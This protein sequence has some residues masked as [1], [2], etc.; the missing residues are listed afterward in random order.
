MGYFDNQ[1]RKKN[2]QEDERFSESWHNLT[3][4]VSG[5]KIWQNIQDP[6]L[7]H[8]NCV[9][10]LADWVNVTL[11][12]SSG[13]N[14]TLEEY[15]ETY[16][17]PQGIMWREVELKDDWYRNYMGIMSGHMKDGTEVVFVPGGKT[18]YTFRD[19]ETGKRVRVTKQNADRFERDAVL[20]YRNLP[21]RKINMKDMISFMLK[22]ISGRDII[23]FVVA[24]IVLMIINMVYPAMTK[25][26]ITHQD[27]I[28]RIF[29]L[30]CTVTLIVF[31]INIIK[32][33][34]LPRISTKIAAPLQAAFMMRVLSA[35]SDQMK[36][37]SAGD[38]GSRI[39]GI[40]MNVQYFMNMLLSV[41]LTGICSLVSFVQMFI[42]SKALA[43]IA[44]LIIFVLIVLLVRIGIRQ[45]KVGEARM[46]SGA[47]EQGLTYSMIDGMQKI[48]LSGAEKRAFA[49][50]ADVYR[51][52]MKSIYNPPVLLK[53]FKVLVPALL[54]ISNLPL[55]YVAVSMNMNQADFFAFTSSFAIVTGAISLISMN[56]TEFANTIPMFKTLKPIMDIE[57]EI[58]RNK[59]VIENLRGSIS[60][61]NITFRY[62]EGMPK[63]IDNLTMNIKAGSYV[64]IVGS[65]GCGKSTLIK[66]LLGFEQP[67]MGEIYYD[68]IPLSSVDMTSLRRRI[69]TVLQNGEIFMGTILHNITIAGTGLTEEDAWR[70]AEIAGIADDIRRMPLKM[71]TPLPDGGRGVSGGQKQRILIARA[72][73][74]RPKVLIFDE[75]TSALDNVTQ[76][77]VSDAIGDLNCTRIV[78][79]HRLSTIQNCSHI[80]CLDKGK[81]IE[82]GSYEE[83][84]EKKGFFAK[85]V[86][87]QQL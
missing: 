47:R 27:E 19:P 61:Q 24:T 53:I 34:T 8:K 60:L 16:F 65:T 85:L 87:K 40:Y 52:S 77:A 54:L 63:I 73:A 12:N 82:E 23:T 11:P 78:I 70:A 26:I 10:E 68:R 1:V 49:E 64:A 39:G 14:M 36:G 71:N 74:T 4:V 38:L 5:P 32:Q 76:K 18:G 33:L 46:L 58:S 7:F 59:K 22:S 67:E 80:F 45:V 44:F 25:R 62:G 41:I 72:I 50:W 55:Y 21:L 29:V 9:A 83:L 20:Y 81:I 43:G 48:S 6:K 28:G 2:E 15:L 57:P 69:G 3:G 66:L 13:D 35:K 42:Y 30:L 51:D 84:M 86:E 31:L 17:R 56:I 79:A 75:A 37:F